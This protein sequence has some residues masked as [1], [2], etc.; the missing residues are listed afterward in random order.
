MSILFEAT[1]DSSLE[2]GL[3]TDYKSQNYFIISRNFCLLN[4]RL[5]FHF[6]TVEAFLGDKVPKTTSGSISKGSSRPVPQ[7]EKDQSD[8][9]NT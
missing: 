7:A 5:G 2:P 8:S 4:T 1:M 6:S 9:K 3:G